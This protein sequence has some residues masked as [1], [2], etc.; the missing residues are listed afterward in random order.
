MAYLFNG[1]NQYLR[2]NSYPQPAKPITVSARFR[3]NTIGRFNVIASL[4]TATSTAAAIEMRTTST[5]T[6][7]AREFAGAGDDAV[8]GGLLSANTW[9]VYGAQYISGVDRRVFLGSS[10]ATAT[11]SV[12]ATT[13]NTLGIGAVFFN[14]A[15]SNFMAGD[16]AEVAIWTAQ[17]TTDEMESLNKGFKPT[18]VRPQSLVFYAP[19]IRDANDIRNANTLNNNNSV[20]ASNHPRVY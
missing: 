1:S 16:V 4:A 13:A 6:V 14:N 3:A 7:V 2:V 12:N 9:Y 5:N 19:L 8:L 17:L 11:G 15:A 20:T 18:R 10:T